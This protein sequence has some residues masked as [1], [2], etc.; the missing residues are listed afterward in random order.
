MKLR[1]PQKRFIEDMGTHM[2]GWG[3]P[4]TTGRVYAYLLLQSAPVSL[5]DVTS[6]LGVAK[7]GAS[8]AMRQLLRMGLARSETQR[9]TRRLLFS[10]LQTIEAIFTARSAQASD[11]VDRLREGAR[12][13]STASTRARLSEMSRRME[14][15]VEG[16]TA[17][18]A[19]AHD[20]GRAAE[21][22]T[23]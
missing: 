17:Q 2:V 3:L 20:I 16:M 18:Y 14:Q 22:G 11:L 15:L 5:D 12:A 21:G 1:E 10:G 23:R 13:A 6:E 7:S 9:G 8:V 19:R 4:R